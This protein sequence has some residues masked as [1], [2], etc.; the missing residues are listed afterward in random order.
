MPIIAIAVVSYIT[1]LIGVFIIG[2]II[3]ALAP[4]FGGQKS[5]IQAMKVAVYSYTAAWVAGVLNILPVLG[6]LAIIAAIYGL[7]IVWLGLRSCEGRT[8]QGEA[9]LFRG[10][11]NRRH[12]GLFHHRRRGCSCHRHHDG[13][14][15]RDRRPHLIR[16]GLGRELAL[17]LSRLEPSLAGVV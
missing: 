16:I 3:D 10:H 13:G 14:S 4:S 2:F 11:D 7:Y 17:G 5:Q 1:A 9:R 8:R 12:C 15:H 6:I